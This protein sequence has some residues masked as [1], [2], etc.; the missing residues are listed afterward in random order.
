MRNAMR[1]WDPPRGK[2]ES[3]AEFGDFPW[4]VR[5]ADGTW[6]FLRGKYEMPCGTFDFLSREDENP[7]RFAILSLAAA[8]SPYHAFQPAARF[9]EFE[10]GAVI[11]SV[12]AN[13]RHRNQLLF[14]SRPDSS[15]RTPRS[16][17]S[18]G[19]QFTISGIRFLGRH[20]AADVIERRRPI[21]YEAGHCRNRNPED[22]AAA[23]GRVGWRRTSP[24][25]R[26]AGL[27]DPA[28]SPQQ[29]GMAKTA[30]RGSNER[31]DLPH[32]AGQR[33]SPRSAR[34]GT[35]RAYRPDFDPFGS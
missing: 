27:F 6:D 4:K 9:P 18:Y 25:K 32:S 1:F 28:H 10:G 26:D 8:K 11:Y 12:S 19:R 23:S 2:C 16:V 29:R 20:A 33:G 15:N 7:I 24:S 31:V 5:N 30:F 35:Q 34:F 22:T 3:C 14:Q 17:Q 21:V 13:F